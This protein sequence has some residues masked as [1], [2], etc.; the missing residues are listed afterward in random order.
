[1]LAYEFF[2][3]HPAKG[4]ELLGILPERRK[5]PKRITHKSVM[6]WVEKVYGNSLNTKDISFNQVMINEY[7]GKIFKPTP[8]LVTQWKFKK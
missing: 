7:T 3:L 4:Y 6:N 1:M 5:N 8:F 2:W